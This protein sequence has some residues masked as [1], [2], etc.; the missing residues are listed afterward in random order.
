MIL[1]PGLTQRG[2]Q[3]WKALGS[4]PV[5]FYKRILAPGGYSNNYWSEQ[6]DPIAGT[7]ANAGAIPAA[8][9]D[10][11]GC[12]LYNGKVLQIGGGVP[13]GGSGVTAVCALY[14]PVAN[15]WSATG[16][17]NTAR[18]VSC[19]T[20][21]LNGKV[22]V[23][24]GQSASATYASCELYDPISGTWRYTGSLAQSR[25]FYPNP[26]SVLLPDGR[27]FVVGG[28]DRSGSPVY[29][30]AEIYN[31][32]TELW[33]SAGSMANTRWEHQATLLLDGRILVSG[34]YNNTSY[35]TACEIYNPATNSWKTVASM[36][37]L[38]ANHTATLLQNGKVLVTGGYNGSTLNSAELYNPVANTWTTV[39][40]SMVSYRF[41][42][43]A[44]L[45]QNGN[46]LLVGGQS[47]G[48]TVLST[49]EIYNA[50]TGQFA[51]TGSMTT[52][53]GQFPLLWF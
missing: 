52:T 39:S 9:A 51:S 10:Q 37:T 8:A 13:G 3:M 47:D 4:P 1:K 46:V 26:A 23:V 25:M 18:N 32:L 22:L 41:V 33:S 5:P 19:A 31:P 48:V 7:W 50:S 30:S 34:G 12:L 43:E 20:T 17:L 24:G 2:S 44:I 40:Y 49:C 36:N 29:A 21:L 16:S 11:N 27:F 6:Y 45:L 14:D 53:R 15:S 42:H 38:R 28:C 35:L